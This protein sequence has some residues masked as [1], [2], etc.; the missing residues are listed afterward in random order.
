MDLPFQR[1][2]AKPFPAAPVGLGAWRLGCSPFDSERRHITRTRIRRQ[3]TVIRG[4]IFMKIHGENQAEALDP[5][6]YSFNING[7][8]SSKI[9]IHVDI[10]FF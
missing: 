8:S 1:W 4:Q 9:S 6:F 5:H 7:F 3:F 10:G 2:K